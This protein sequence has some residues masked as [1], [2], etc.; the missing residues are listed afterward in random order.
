MAQA[1]SQSFHQHPLRFSVGLA[2]QLGGM[3]ALITQL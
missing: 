2:I 1:I 3:L